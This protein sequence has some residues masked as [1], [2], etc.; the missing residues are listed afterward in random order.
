VDIPFI[1][2]VFCGSG[3]GKVHVFGGKAKDK[4]HPEIFGYV[5]GMT[6]T[7]LAPQAN[8]TRAQMIKLMDNLSGLVD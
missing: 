3:A 8:L 7:T 5:S 1:R 6:E 4:V 2:S